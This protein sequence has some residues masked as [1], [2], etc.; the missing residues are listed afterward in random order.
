VTDPL[1][2][3]TPS[4]THTTDIMPSEAPPKK[5]VDLLK[6]NA[7]FENQPEEFYPELAGLLEHRE[8]ADG[9]VLIKEGEHVDKMIL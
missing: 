1:R 2:E 8:L 7:Y 9:E 6:I 5:V 3:V 4:H